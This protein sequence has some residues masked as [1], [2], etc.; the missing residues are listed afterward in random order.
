MSYF[1]R[2]SLILI[3]VIIPILGIDLSAFS[4]RGNEDAF[5]PPSETASP[6]VKKEVAHSSFAWQITTT[7]TA[8]PPNM[9]D[10]G[11]TPAS[12]PT[13][14]GTP[15]IRLDVRSTPVL[16][17]FIRAPYGSVAKP[18]V[19][20]T[21]YRSVAIERPLEIE[22]QVDG[23]E[24]ICPSTPCQ[25]PISDN[26]K[27]SF[28]AQDP[29]GGASDTVQATVHVSSG[30]TGYAVI[31]EQVS[32]YFAHRD[33]CSIQWGFDAQDINVPWSN[34]PQQ[35]ELL[36]TNKTL[37]YL[38]GHLIRAGIVDARDC[39]GGG[40]DQRGAPNLCGLE[41]ARSGMIE[42]QNM[43]DFNIWLSAKDMQIPPYILKFVIEAESQFWPSNERSYVDEIGIGQI[44]QLGI[45]V[46]LRTDPSL[47][48]KICPGVLGDCSVP[49]PAL[50]ESLQKLIRGALLNSLNANCP[51]C[52]YGIDLNVARNSVSFIG[53]LL[54]ANCKQ[55]QKVMELYDA[56]ASY[57]DHWKF[58]LMSYHTG[59]SCVENA[60]ERLT[61]E[62]EA[63]DWKHVARKTDCL[64]GPEYVE[65]VW[66]SLTSFETA[67]LRIDDNFFSG[68]TPVFLPTPTPIPTIG[69]PP[70]SAELWCI[71]I[72]DENRNGIPEETEWVSGILVT[73][74]YPDGTERSVVTSNGKAVFNLSD[75]PTGAIVT[76]NLPS[77]YRSSTVVVPREGVVPVVFVFYPAPITPIS[78]PSGNLP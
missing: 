29:F 2:A 52:P 12:L 64:G 38:A 22:G 55:V 62:N 26:S 72:L 5:I 36:A 69:P 35:P 21:A 43:F 76:V 18:F 71:V 9:S 40:I 42:W 19:I 61:D 27:I 15:I 14:T 77:L 75:L 11:V 32:Q 28:H 6:S 54:R 4:G 74:T 60:V 73:I 53:L 41:R 57:E 56:E 50:P 25:I 78:S 24:F 67:R 33:A 51:N 66:G 13:M 59:L 65:R 45:D 20:L 58:T 23:I 46:L 10:P 39:P 31:L 17:T 7:P 70:S 34:F 63:T 48:Y 3:L 1:F 49:Y 68:A 44:N 8:T 47:Y 30:E 37:H 16:Y